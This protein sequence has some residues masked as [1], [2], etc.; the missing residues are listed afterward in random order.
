MLCCSTSPAGRTL[1]YRKVNFN[2]KKTKRTLTRL[3]WTCE[4]GTK[5]RGKQPF[6]NEFFARTTPLNTCPV[7]A[8]IEFEINSLSVPIFHPFL[9]RPC[10]R[11]PLISLP[12][13]DLLGLC[14]PVDIQNW[15]VCRYHLSFPSG[16]TWSLQDPVWRQ[17]NTPNHHRCV[18]TIVQ[19]CS[20]DQHV[21]E[22]N[23]SRSA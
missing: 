9:L 10:G 3:F 16:L 7:L 21:W 11:M 8:N 4:R 22:R 2:S 5:R 19:Q 12:L 1:D 17:L 23:I 18:Q 13:T 20:G 14:K 6:K 15:Q